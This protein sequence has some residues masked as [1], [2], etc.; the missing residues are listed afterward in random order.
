MVDKYVREAELKGKAKAVAK[1]TEEE[2]WDWLCCAA[3]HGHVWS[4]DF[5]GNI[6]SWIEAH[7]Q[8]VG[9]V[10]WEIHKPELLVRQG[11]VPDPIPA[12]L[13]IRAYQYCL[14]TLR[15]TTKLIGPVLIF[16][17]GYFFQKIADTL[18]P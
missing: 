11:T 10:L 7:C 5:G 17:F 6:R 15:Q 14:L 1:P 2:L 8:A 13:E 16:I 18:F 9:D 12:T 4:P 3:F